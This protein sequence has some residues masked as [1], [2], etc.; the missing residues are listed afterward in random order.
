MAGVAARAR[1]QRA[2]WVAAISR[3]KGPG[4]EIAA[5]RFSAGVIMAALVR[6]VTISTSSV[7]ACRS[8]LLKRRI[9]ASL[10]LWLPRVRVNVLLDLGLDDLPDGAVFLQ[11]RFELIRAA[12]LP[13]P[14]C[15]RLS[16]G[17]DLAR[18]PAE[19]L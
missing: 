15:H 8:C 14:V 6:G 17:N 11:H 1:N 10:S 19:D 4:R 9:V 5:K 2:E 3:L 7:G 18:S 12:V 13:L 16:K